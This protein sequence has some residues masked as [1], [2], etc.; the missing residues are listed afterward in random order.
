LSKKNAIPKDNNII[1][2]PLEEAMPDN[3][4]P[5]AVE[6]AKDRAL[7]DVRDGLKPV[8]RR[9]LYGTYLLKAFPDR[10]YFKSARIVGDILGKF[11]PHGD[12]SVYDSMVILAQDFTTRAPLIDGHGN[13]GSMDGDSAAAMRYTEARLSK[14]A[15]EMIRDI[16]KDTVDFTPNYSDTEME[17]VVL[18]ARYPN[19]LVNGAFGIAVG[20]ATNIPPHNMR[21][22]INATCAFIDDP[23]ITTE[24]LM[25]HVK[26]PDLPTGGILI[27]EEDLKQAYTTGEG[28]VT[29]RSRC[30]IERL[31]NGRLGIVITEFPYRKNKARLLQQISD[32][33]ADKKHQKALESITDIRDESDRTGVRAVI[34]FKKAVDEQTAEK[35]LLYLYKRCDLQINLNFNMVALSKGKPETMGLKRIIREYVAHQKEIITRRTLKELDIA[36]KRFHIVEGFM[37]AIDVLDEVIKTIRQST[38][39]ANAAD[40]L[41]SAFGF[42]EPQAQAI[43]ELMLYRLTGLELKVYIKE[44]AELKKL[45]ASLE[46]II[47]SEKELMKLIKK[48]LLEVSANFGDDRRTE[49]IA[50]ATEA[51]IDASDIMVEEDVM[52]TVSKDGFIKRLPLKNFQRVSSDVSAIDYRE[53]DSCRVLVQSNTKEMLYVFGSS[54]MLYQ[55]KTHLLPDLKWKEKGERLDEFVKGIDLSDE[56]I[57]AAFTV[58]D[59]DE[60]AVVK[61]LTTRGGLKRTL[62]ESFKTNYTK[63]SGVKLKEG[64]KVCAV[65]LERGRI[66]EDNT[67][68]ELLPKA[69]KDSILERDQIQSAGIPEKPMFVRILTDRGLDF[70]VPEAD[71]QVKDRMIVPDQFLTMPPE[72]AIAR[73]HFENDYEAREF[74]LTVT[75][76]G[77]IKVTARAGRSRSTYNVTGAS[78]LS[79]IAVTSL[80]AYCKI[81]MYL[82]ENLQEP[83]S[84]SDLYGDMMKGERV[85]GVFTMEDE[86]Y[87]DREVYMATEG[88]LVKRTPISDFVGDSMSGS[89]I[90][91]KEPGDRLAYAGAF[92][93]SISASMLMVTE[94][95]MAI[96]FETES[97]SLLSKNASGVVGINLKEE[98]RVFFAS[99]VTNEKELVLSSKGFPDKKVPL[100]DIKLQNRAARGKN[101]FM[102]VL[103]DKVS[104][105]DII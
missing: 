32:M 4:L 40:N 47:S 97:I 81:P 24:G 71:V 101:V 16:D 43:L 58:R 61:F 88:G 39:R 20:L 37:K 50:D 91:F 80:G 87:D 69:Y 55:I 31:P 95:G 89:V 5:Y 38:S 62:L 105:A 63:I 42:T 66:L 15:L 78:Y 83:I 28:K 84:L 49:I 92:P 14:V 33:T 18:P 99:V 53:G 48:E 77:E 64:E 13:W 11:H 27:G 98:D 82:F 34:E 8:H 46:R 52:V 19:L 57:V 85:V 54:G 26:G 12:A 44:H 60:E 6:V 35:I 72:D 104:K 103:G 45:I 9:I 67:L 102:V 74:N 1:N 76:K 21:E 70:T 36:R 56:E 75:E 17:P 10:P 86:L 23:E 3:Y 7:P 68:G 41:M 96:R 93:G 90:R 65:V 79:L 29:L 94:K 51:V 59:P 100:E 30:E 73:V 2:V 22:V 25:Q